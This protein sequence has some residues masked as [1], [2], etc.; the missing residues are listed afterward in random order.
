M[1]WR[2]ATAVAA[3]SAVVLH[4]LLGS[5]K[6]SLYYRWLAKHG[7]LAH[8]QRHLNLLV[9]KLRASSLWAPAV[10]LLMYAQSTSVWPIPWLLPSAPYRHFQHVSCCNKLSAL[11]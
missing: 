1:S 3:G 7:S 10:L 6:W 4:D 9:C 8:L 5:S 11:P 2:S